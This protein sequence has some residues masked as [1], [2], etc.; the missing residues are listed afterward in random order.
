ML[1]RSLPMATTSYKCRKQVNLHDI[2]RAARTTGPCPRCSGVLRAPWFGLG[3]C[4][5]LPQGVKCPSK[6]DFG[7]FP[8]CWTILQGAIGPP[9]KN[10]ILERSRAPGPCVRRI[11]EKSGEIPADGPAG[12]IWPIFF[13]FRRQGGV[14]ARDLPEKLAKTGPRVLYVVPPPPILYLYNIFLESHHKPQ[15]GVFLTPLSYWD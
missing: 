5:F 7:D 15:N 8:I 4:G 9:L 13:R 3:C 6:H 10:T 14:G 1:F 12:G 11:S 2:M